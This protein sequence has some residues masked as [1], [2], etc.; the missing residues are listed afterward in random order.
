MRLVKPGFRIYVLL[1]LFVI[2]GIVYSVAV[3]PFEA[4]DEL[5]HYPMVKTIADNWALPV[6]DPANVGPWRQEGSQ[7]PLYY[8]ISAVATAWIDTSDME[9]IRWVNPHADNGVITEDGNINLIVHTPASG[10][11]L[12]PAAAR[13]YAVD[14]RRKGWQGTVLAIH[15]IRLLQI[16]CT[17]LHPA[18]P[19]FFAGKG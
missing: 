12:D 14:Q 6:Q 4:S 7:A 19:L 3:P 9:Q 11:T 17:G 2:L 1:V 10:L 15:L 18:L 16:K 13:S 5:W 8:L